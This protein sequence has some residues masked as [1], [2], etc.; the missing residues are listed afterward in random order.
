MRRD[1]IM[2]WGMNAPEVGQPKTYPSKYSHAQCIP[3]GAHSK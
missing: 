1:V 3:I 2:G